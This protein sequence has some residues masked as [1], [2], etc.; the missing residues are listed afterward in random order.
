MRQGAFELVLVCALRMSA[1][2]CMSR[3]LEH[4]IIDS[5]RIGGFTWLTS[6]L[7][8][9]MATIRRHHDGFRGIGSNGGLG[10]PGKQLLEIAVYSRLFL[11]DEQL[12]RGYRCPWSLSPL[13]VYRHL[14]R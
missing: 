8:Q 2:F 1:Q 4:R 7:L 12:K 3:T 5:S 14:H 6:R 11:L 10:D 13:V 9:M